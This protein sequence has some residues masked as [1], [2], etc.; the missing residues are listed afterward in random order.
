[1]QKIRADIIAGAKLITK[2][3]LQTT[4]NITCL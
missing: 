4:A 3:Q 1:M 2:Y